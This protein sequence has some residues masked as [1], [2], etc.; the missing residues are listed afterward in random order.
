MIDG[1]RIDNVRQDRRAG[2]V[3]LTRRGRVVLVA[4]VVIIL[5]VGFWVTVR[6]GAG[7]S[8]GGGETP[9]AR[10]T[11]AGPESVE[12]RWHDTLWD[13]ASRGRP[14]VDP[15]VTVQ[16]IIDLNGLSGAIVQPG[17]RL[18]LPAR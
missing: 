7:A 15:R 10:V 18:K 8:P 6:R 17:Q 13:I 9:A 1:V 3:R 11:G 16:R 5:L 4:L 14:E 12:V 2:G